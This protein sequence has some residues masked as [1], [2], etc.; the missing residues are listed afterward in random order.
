MD[1]SEPMR[2]ALAFCR[3]IKSSKLVR[4]EFEKVVNEFQAQTQDDR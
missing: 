3:D 2:R 1:D 4:D